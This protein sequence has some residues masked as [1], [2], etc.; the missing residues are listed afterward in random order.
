D[1]TPEEKGAKLIEL[2]KL[3]ASHDEHIIQA[4]ANL[5]EWDQKVLVTNSKGIYQD[6]VRTYSRVALVAVAQDGARM[7][8]AYEA[9]GRNMGFEIFDE[10]DF[11]ALAKEV[12]ESVMTYLYA[13][14]MESQEL[15]VVIHNG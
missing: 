3:I 6:D 2:S 8:E 5:I 10:I 7:Q 1:V 15:P 11:K 9:P 12:G 13:D 14:N 4:G